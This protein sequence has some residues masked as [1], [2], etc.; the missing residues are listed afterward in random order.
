MKLVG[1]VKGYYIKTQTV[2]L[3]PIEEKRILKCLRYLKMLIQNSEKD[4]THNLLPHSALT[5]GEELT[6]TINNTTKI[7]GTRSKFTYRCFS[8]ITLYQLKC[9]LANRIALN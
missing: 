3:L 7:P 8:N 2:K 5:Q 6:L 9:D 4:G 1:E